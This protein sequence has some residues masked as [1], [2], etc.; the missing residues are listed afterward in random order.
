M[1]F[2]SVLMKRWEAFLPLRLDY[3]M[4]K[5]LDLGILS[6]TLQDLVQVKRLSALKFLSLALMQLIK[7]LIPQVK[8]MELLHLQS[9]TKKTLPSLMHLTAKRL[10]NLSSHFNKTKRELP[11]AKTKI[12]QIYQSTK[13]CLIT[14]SK[15]CM[16]KKLLQIQTNTT[17]TIKIRIIWNRKSMLIQ[18]KFKLCSKSN[19]LNLRKLK[20]NLKRKRKN[21]RLLLLTLVNS[22]TT[23]YLKVYKPDKPRNQI[24]LKSVNQKMLRDASLVVQVKG[25]LVHLQD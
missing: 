13:I 8:C 16:R 18:R 15:A 7:L 2:H 11:G 24:C 21:K 9:L 3:L 6:K 23:T 20:I 1:L 12:N 22:R 10:I 14:H 17:L 5:H 25:L 19:L 4:Y